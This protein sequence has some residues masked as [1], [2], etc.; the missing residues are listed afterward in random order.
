MALTTA[1]TTLA[2]KA[3]PR[4]GFGGAS[5][6]WPAFSSSRITPPNPDASAKAPWTRTIVGPGMGFSSRLERRP[7]RRYVTGPERAGPG[8]RWPGRGMFWADPVLSGTV[9]VGDGI[10]PYGARAARS[11]FP[12]PSPGISGSDVERLPGIL[13]HPPVPGTS[14]L[15]HTRPFPQRRTA[16]IQAC[17]KTAASR[18]ELP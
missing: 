17:P 2:S 9:A 3:T 15:P 16:L 6:V 5:T 1:P 12:A 8:V 13:H 7:Q 4:N 14:W 18:R 10:P 11:L